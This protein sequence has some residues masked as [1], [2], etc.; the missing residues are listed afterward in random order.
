MFDKVGRADYSDFFSGPKREHDPAMKPLRFRFSFLRERSRQ[1][2][3]CGR[4]GRIIVGA[5]MNLSFL[6]FP[7]H[8]AGLAETE[9]IVMRADHDVLGPLLW[10]RRREHS[11]DIAVF[12]LDVFHRSPDVDRDIRKREAAFRMGIL[13][14]ESGLER[15]QI[16]ARAQKERVRHVAGDARRDDSRIGHAGIKRG[17]H[18]LAFIWGIRSGDEQHRLRAMLARQHRLVSQPGVTVQLLPPFR[19]DL[20]RDVAQDKRNLVLNI[21]PGIRIVPFCSFARHR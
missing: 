4:A 19:I 20:L 3:D 21:H 13:L 12:L 1:F 7:L 9:V 18:E 2:Q 16:F 5:R 17:R 10:T 15:F 6:A 14:V 8:R 11:D